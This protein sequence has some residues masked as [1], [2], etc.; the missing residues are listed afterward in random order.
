MDRLT[1]IRGVLFIETVDSFCVP[2]TPWSQKNMAAGQRHLLPECPAPAVQ[3]GIRKK[4]ILG[5]SVHRNGA[6][7]C[8]P[9]T[10]GLS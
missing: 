8:D 10:V 6:G 5:R 9:H 3:L 7:H 1:P 4:T 2:K